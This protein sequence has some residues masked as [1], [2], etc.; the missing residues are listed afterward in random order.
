LKAKFYEEVYAVERK[1]QELYQPL[2][3]K[4]KQI[5]VGEYEPTDAE[6]EFKSDDEDD[7]EDGITEDMAK[8]AKEFE[9]TLEK[10]PADL[11]GVPDFWLTIFKSVELLSDMV[12]PHDEPILR[13]LLDVKIIY[14]ETPMAY[15]LEFHFGANDWFKDTV[16]TKK[17]YL[18]CQIDEDKP[19]TFGGPEIYKCTGCTIDW[20]PSKN[21]TVKTIKKKQKHKARGAVRTITK[22]LPNDSFFNFFNPP[23][24]PE[25]ESK[26]DEDAQEIL[27]T[28]FEIGHF[29]RACIIPKAALYFSGELVD[30]DDDEDVSIVW[31]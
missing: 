2:A 1:Y 28:D 30:D 18:R 4:R 12:Q 6:A 15:T 14:E 13:K 27:G 24:V 20:N 22:T 9:K 23:D 29:L 19:F 3:N 10:Y 16:L 26:L 17:Y 8:M 11:K 31:P 25:D 7:N 5:I 21:V